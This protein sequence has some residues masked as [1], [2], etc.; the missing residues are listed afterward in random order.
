M[1]KLL[2]LLS[3][4]AIVLSCSSDETATPVTPPPAPIV[5]Y[6][7]TLSAGEGGT[8]ST[9]GG[10]YEAGQTVNVTATPQGE[11]VFTSWSDGNTD[12]TRTI[13]VSSNTTLT[14]NFQRIN[15][16]DYFNVS[17]GQGGDFSINAWKSDYIEKYYS[18]IHAT[19]DYGWGLDYMDG[20]ALLYAPNFQGDIFRP[21]PIY[22]YDVE[23]PVDLN[24]K[25]V[26]SH[27][28]ISGNPFKNLALQQIEKASYNNKRPFLHKNYDLIV[29]HLR[30]NGFENSFI[31]I[32]LGNY[33]SVLIDYNEDGILDL[34][35]PTLAYPEGLTAASQRHSVGFFKSN[36]N[37]Y[38]EYDSEFSSKYKGLFF[39]ADIEINDFNNDGK[40]D[41]LAVGTSD[42]TNPKDP[43]FK[44]HPILY[45]NNGNGNFTLIEFSDFKK[46]HH[47]SASGDI[48]N[49][50]DI[51]IVLINPG[52]IG[53]SDQ[54][55][56]DIFINN[57]SGE[58][59]HKDILINN[60]IESLGKITSE[61]YDMNNDGF[62][63]LVLGGK[64]SDQFNNNNESPKNGLM[65]LLGNGDN[66]NNEEIIL[67]EIADYELILDLD[68]I[69][70][71]NDNFND[72][73]V[74][75]ASKDY[76]GFYIQIIKNIDGKSFSDVTNEVI[77][78][79]YIVGVETP[80]AVS[81]NE[82]VE[83]SGFFVYDVVLSD[84]DGDNI[85]ELFI[86]NLNRF[87]KRSGNGKRHPYRHWDIIGGKFIKRTS[88][89]EF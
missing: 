41:F 80:D 79:N 22:I 15:P 85:K 31:K 84:T 30:E 8:V 87:T 63:D 14:A 43:N 35:L 45:L 50:G 88:F 11:Y 28:I 58:F 74:T 83:D 12:S 64:T 89:K 25:F 81:S 66:F 5:K 51:D 47:S 61:L 20:N 71:N 29:D 75:R 19:P 1:K 46:Y 60:P 3:V 27:D 40:L 23:E 18:I 67:P 78:D 55:N 65:I 56:G 49:D 52:F 82:L 77:T 70:F 7:I 16:E 76:W 53:N 48:D 54:N 37:G 17:L 24:I 4:F 62:L 21:N 72:L 38:L 26:R 44:D 36:S 34:I 9:T 33:S 42:E 68:F 73:I 59:E 57:G 32:T 13:T 86:N 10:E 69:D 2:S 39:C 6:T